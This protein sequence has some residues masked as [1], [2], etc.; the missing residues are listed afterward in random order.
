M[1]KNTIEKF[2]NGDHKNIVSNFLSLSFLQGANLILPLLTFPY[3]VKTL[4]I[5]KYGLIMFAQ[6][7]MTYFTMVADYGFNL[8]GT[9]EI[10]LHRKNQLKL[11]RIYN[12]ILIARLSMVTLGFLIMAIIVLSIANFASEW[13]LY[14]LT[15]GMVLGTALFPT[16]FF[17]GM[18]KMKYITILTVI[19]KA[20]FTISIFVIVVSPDDYLWV[21][22]LNSFGFVFVGLISLV[23][24]NSN[25]KIP[26]KIQEPKYIVQQIKKGWHI[27]ISKISTNLYTATTTFVLGLVTNATM[28]G[29]YAIAEKLIRI[30][31]AMFSPFTQAIYPHIV[32][33]TNKSPEESILFLRKML[34]YT[35]L[36]TLIIWGISMAFAAPMFHLII[37]NEVDHSILLFRILSP[38]IVI[39]PVASVLF[40]IILLSFKMD[41]FF[42]R[43][44]I[45]GAVIN[46]ALLGIFLFL[47]QL[48]TVG[49]ALSLLICETVN[50]VYAGILLYK[51]NIKVFSFWSNEV[52][53]NKL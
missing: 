33:L 15:Y 53:L 37:N 49:A 35:I 38:L 10:S 8:S 36:I 12:S 1:I 25:F 42:S 40:N 32:Q 17:Q 46:I 48:S 31:V 30:I 34:K 14:F 52:S 4:G 11:T 9:R 2:K 16:W 29:Y 39:I 50:T 6:A 28:V 22:F 20:I 26:F 45:T 41:T 51:N 21:P 7:F 43:I 13:K 23:I 3:L 18:E 5:E 24:I 44:Y 27:F 19:S 47:I